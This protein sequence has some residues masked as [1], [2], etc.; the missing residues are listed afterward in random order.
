MNEPSLHMTKHGIARNS[1]NPIVSVAVARPQTR[2]SDTAWNR[3]TQLIARGHR[4]LV[5]EEE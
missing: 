5:D 2:T 1:R 4:A 3:A